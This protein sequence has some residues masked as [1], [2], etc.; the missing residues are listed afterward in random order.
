MDKDYHIYLQSLELDKAGDWNGAH[1]LIQD[2]NSQEA[3]WLHAY[4]HRKEGDESNARYWYGRAGKPFF[5]G[6]LEDEWQ[7][8]WKAFSGN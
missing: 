6:S 2:V 4:L 3:S 7:I 8:I 1:E 5:N